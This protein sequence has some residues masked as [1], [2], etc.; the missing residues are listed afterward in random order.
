MAAGVPA[1]FHHVRDAA[2]GGTR[3]VEP[4]CGARRPGVK[5]LGWCSLVWGA[6]VLLAGCATGGGWGRSTGMGHPVPGH[7]AQTADS[8]T[9][10]CLNNPACYTQVG[11]EA[12]IPW[13][14]RTASAVRTTAAVMKFLET[15][16]VKLVEQILVECVKDAHDEVNKG[17]F[18]EEG[19]I[20]TDEQCNEVVRREGDQD[21]TRAMDLGTKKHERASECVKDKL[22]GRLLQNVTVGPRYKYDPVSKRWRMLDPEA[23]AKWIEE[24]LFELL[25]GTLAPDVVMHATGNP[26]KVQRVYDFKFPCLSSRKSN[27]G[28][29]RSQGQRKDQRDKYGD[30]LGGEDD[31]ALISPQLGLQR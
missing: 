17:E 31:P 30:A 29:R 16:D 4:E 6:L 27:P 1:N 9:S 7:Y 10:T 28:W 5:R 24:K 15:A 2:D 26:D 11:D 18:G 14:T 13:L 25:R 20:P 22:G 23:V 8:A 3:D 21:V 19:Y 12:I